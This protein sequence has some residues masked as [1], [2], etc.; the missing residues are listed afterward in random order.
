MGR[1]RMVVRLTHDAVRRSSSRKDSAPDD[2]GHGIAPAGCGGR[3]VRHHPE[4]E[5]QRPQR[6]ARAR[7]GHEGEEHTERFHGALSGER[8]PRF[9]GGGH[10]RTEGDE[11]EQN[12]EETSD[13]THGDL[14]G[15]G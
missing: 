11:D 4:G 12:E 15:G 13:E 14:R 8:S 1:E 3:G 10:A 2:A 9:D 7:D 6:T 5:S